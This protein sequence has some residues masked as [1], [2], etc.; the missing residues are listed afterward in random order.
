MTPN[1]RSEPARPAGSLSLLAVAALAIS[2]SACAAVPAS[3]VPDP[4]DPLER[5]NRGMDQF[6]TAVDDAV[7]QPVAKGYKAAVPSFVRTGVGNFFANLGDVWSMVN[8]ALQGNGPGFGDSMGRVMLNTF[9]GVGGLFDVAS[10]AGIQRH[11]E[12]FGQTLGVW[13]VPPGP[14]LVLPLLGSSTVRDTVA[15]PLDWKGNAW[16]HVNDIPWRNSGTALSIV[17]TRARFLDAS[18]LINDAA[19]DPYT[20]KRDFYLQK[21]RSDVYDGYPPDVQERYDLPEGEAENAADAAQPT[22]QSAPAQ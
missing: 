14:Y 1:P 8:N 7:L 22:A 17:D 12:D 19:L 2:L 9:V 5:Y 15:L 4:R 20:F 10:E 3:S 11:K 13:G 18:S 21:R 6:N 16:S